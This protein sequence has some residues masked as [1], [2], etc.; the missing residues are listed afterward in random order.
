[1]AKLNIDGVLAMMGRQSSH[2][3]NLFMSGFS[4]EKRVRKDH[5]LRKIAETI[6]FDFIYGEVKDTYGGDSWMY[7]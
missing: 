3:Y 6:D 7:R 2:Q 1:M 4:L 5:I